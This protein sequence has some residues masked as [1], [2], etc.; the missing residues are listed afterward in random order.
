M[1]GFMATHNL[2][3]SNVPLLFSLLEPNIDAN[4][5]VA[6]VESCCAS[7]SPVVFPFVCSLVQK[8]RPLKL[9]GNRMENRMA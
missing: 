5:I 4:G 1:I 2:P 9:V 8:G 3:S 6:V 7:D